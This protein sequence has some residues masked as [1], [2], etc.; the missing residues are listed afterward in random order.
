MDGG[1]RRPVLILGATKRTSSLVEVAGEA[2]DEG[3]RSCLIDGRCNSELQLVSA[4]RQSEAD[5]QRVSHYQH[6][7]NQRRP[8]SPAP[9]RLDLGSTNAAQSQARTRS[10]RE[11]LCRERCCW[12]THCGAGRVQPV[13]RRMK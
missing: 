10:E 11:A 13:A 7:I 4:L 2:E 9:P 8:P 12:D 3:G 6:R 1:S 5:L